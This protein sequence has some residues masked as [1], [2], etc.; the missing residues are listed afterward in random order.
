MFGCYI[1][2]NYSFLMRDRKEV[3]GDRSGGEKELGET[4]RGE[5]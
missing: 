4:E 5:L 2:K 3:I 1:L